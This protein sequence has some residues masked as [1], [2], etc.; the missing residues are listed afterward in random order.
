MVLGVEIVGPYKVNDFG[1]GRYSITCAN[2]NIG[3]R[4]ATEEDVKKLREKYEPSDSIFTK[5]K[6]ITEQE[7]NMRMLLTPTIYKL[8]DTDGREAFEYY[9][10]KEGT[11]TNKMRKAARFIAT[12][13]LGA[14]GGIG[15]IKYGHKIPGLLKKVPSVLKKVPEVLKKVPEFLKQIPK[16]FATVK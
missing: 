1:G 5:E 12:L 14:I 7:A 10:N 11:V 4:M 2:G 9:A 8:F 6:Q 16:F 15:Y 3:A 13:A